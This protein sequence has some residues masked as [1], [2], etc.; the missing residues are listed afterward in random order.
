MAELLRNPEK[1][2]KIR[3]ELQQV[4][5]KY[6]QQIEESHISRLPFIGAVVK[7]TLRL[8]PPAP[9]LVPHKLGENVEL[10]G[11]MVPENAQILVN[12]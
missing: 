7:E 5:G 3:K 8:H 4:I 12:L 2:E 6:E 10:C 9:L 1:L 11:S